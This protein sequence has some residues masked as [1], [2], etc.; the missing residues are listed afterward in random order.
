M[1]IQ[2]RHQAKL[3]HCQQLD[4]DDAEAD[5]KPWYHDIK[6]Y[7]EKGAYPSR[8]TVND[9][10]ML[11]RFVVGFFLSGT[12]LYKRSTDWTLLCYV[13]EQEAKGIM[14]EY[15]HQWPRL[16]SQNSQSQLLLDQNGV[17][18]LSACK[19][20]MKCEVYTD[21]IHVVPYNIHNLTSPW[22]FAM[23]GLN[24]IG[25]IEPKVSNGHRFILVAIDYFTKWVEAA[26]Y[27][28]V[29]K[30]VVVK[31]IKRDII[32]RYGLLAHIITNNGTNLNNKMKTK[33]C[34]QFKIKHH[35]S[36]PYRPKMN[37]VVE[38]ANKNIKKIMQKMVVTYKD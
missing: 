38:A 36:T 18:L 10:R 5:G 23:W 12:I 16:S 19:K 2:V 14:E 24:M 13:D 8:A 30:C 34:E 35:N 9:K 3:A 21:N 26:S 33:L 37:G 11:R 32:H 1:T 20:C 27:A 7:L 29:T 25:P 17:G 22:P 15:P 28:S 4:W 31:F 6:G